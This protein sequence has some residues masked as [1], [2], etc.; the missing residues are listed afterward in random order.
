MWRRMAKG[1]IE[2]EMG[3]DPQWGAECVCMCVYY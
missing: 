3:R 1:Q 2:E